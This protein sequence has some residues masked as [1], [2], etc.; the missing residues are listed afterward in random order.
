MLT[1]LEYDRISRRLEKMKVIHGPEWVNATLI[2]HKHIRNALLEYEKRY[3]IDLE[4]EL[5]SH[6]GDS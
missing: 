2:R 1:D 3:I 6:K 5:I 4:S